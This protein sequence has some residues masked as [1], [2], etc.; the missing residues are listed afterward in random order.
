[1]NHHEENQDYIEVCNLK[2]PE[3]M[4]NLMGKKI[5]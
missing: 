5:F 4:A 3:E 2:N 1:M